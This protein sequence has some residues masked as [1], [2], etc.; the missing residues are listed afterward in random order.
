MSAVHPASTPS[1]AACQVGSPWVLRILKTPEE[2]AAVEELIRTVW[3]GDDLEVVPAHL[4]L[5]LAHNGGLVTGAFADGR[6]VGFVFGFPGLVATADGLQVKHCSHELGVHPEYRNRGLGFELKRFQ[7]QT[8]RDQGIRRV[9]WTYDPLL[10]RNAH[11]NIAKLG[12]VC[13]TYLRD[14]YGELRDH[15]NAGLPTDRFQVD[16]WVDSPRVA[17]RMA[18]NPH[19]LP[20]LRDYL[21]D[22][23]S[24]LNP[25][26]RAGVVEPPHEATAGA[27]GMDL[28]HI[29]TPLLVEIPTDFL[30]VKA[31]DPDLALAWRLGTQTCFEDLF[32]H[33]FAVTDFLHEP[34]PPSR[35]IYVLRR[36]EDAS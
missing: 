11:L 22:G 3:P 23:A 31:S 32:G 6:L 27:W 19:A 34:G 14:A 26:N 29:P 12:A 8:V 30:S 28:K 24:L 13:N 17:A 4:L 21:R 16:W 20:E 36:E 25:V 15:F 9:T 5:A 7:R 33:G 18:E 1:P 35:A 10:S 2:M